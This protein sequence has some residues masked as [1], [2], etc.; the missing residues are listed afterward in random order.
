MAFRVPLFETVEIERPTPPD[1]YPPIAAE[2]G[3]VGAVAAGL[4]GLVVGGAVGAGY[5]FAKKL[6][7]EEGGKTP[8]PGD[9]KEVSS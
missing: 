1:T 3:R 5:K 7:A 8:P 6:G 4:T 2:Q 9:D